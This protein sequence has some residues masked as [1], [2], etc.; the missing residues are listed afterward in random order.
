MGKEGLLPSAKCKTNGNI[1]DNKGKVV[2]IGVSRD[3]EAHARKAN[4]GSQIFDSD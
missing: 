1:S 2:K 3:S 4:E